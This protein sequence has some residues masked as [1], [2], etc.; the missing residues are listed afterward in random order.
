MISLGNPSG[1]IGWGGGGVLSKSF[2]ILNVRGTIKGLYCL[3][4]GGGGEK[5]FGKDGK[6]VSEFL[7][8]PLLF[9]MK[10]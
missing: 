2:Q 9:V 3:E 1:D 6:R 7:F 8:R 10:Y 5:G 4:G